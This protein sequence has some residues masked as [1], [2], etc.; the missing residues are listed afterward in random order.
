MY[1]LNNT[2]LHNQC[3]KEESNGKSENTSIG[4]HED[5]TYQNLWDAMKLLLSQKY[6]S[7]WEKNKKN[8]KW[9]T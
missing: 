9:I 6:K 5:T 8:L 4:K 2:F 7:N 3:I 1:K